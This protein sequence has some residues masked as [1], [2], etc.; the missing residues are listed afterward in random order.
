MDNKSIKIPELV[1]PAG[2]W[3]ALNSAVAA[4]ADSIYFGVKGVNMR[5][6]AS[7]FD[8][9]EIKKIMQTLHNKNKKGYL[10][11]NV[12]M[13]NKEADKIRNILEEAK[14]C[15]VDA[16]IL[17]DMGI[18]HLA[19]KIGIKIHLSTQASVSNFLSLKEYNPF[20]VRRAVFARECELED[21]KQIITQ[22][23]CEELDCDV[24][25]FIHGAMCISISG[26]C[27][28]SEHTFLKS[29]NRGECV[30]PCRREFVIK[31]KDNESEY[32]LGEDYLLSPKDLCSIDFI[33]KLIESGISAFKIEGR[34]RSQEYTKV[35]TSVYRQ[36]IDSYFKGTFNEELKKELKEQLYSV[37]NRGFSDGFYFGRPEKAISRKLENNYEKIF[38]GEVVKFYKKI[39]V[40]EIRIRNGELKKGDTILCIGKKTPAFFTDVK[41]I[42]VNHVFV[43]TLN[44]GD[45]GGVKLLSLAK[46]KDKVFIWREKTYKNI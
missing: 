20:G 19:K 9:L 42:Q 25:A 27:F 15:E 8:I 46:P 33:D 6:L 43:N 41:D 14:K 45:V 16:V 12:I 10:A 35:V 11:L 38:L 2:N 44:R 40:A 30:Q 3:S 36:A 21:I 29:A 23:K 31:D 22:S 5:N 26:R 7:N 28:L 1:S 17:W 37:Y 32:I 13:Y 39:G 34:N 18:F 24:E 4:G